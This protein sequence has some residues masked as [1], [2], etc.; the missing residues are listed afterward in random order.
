MVVQTKAE[1]FRGRGGYQSGPNGNPYW[2]KAF[3]NLV[4]AFWDFYYKINLHLQ[5]VSCISVKNQSLPHSAECWPPHLTNVTTN[6]VQSQR[7]L[8]DSKVCSSSWF[9]IFLYY[10]DFLSW[11]IEFLSNNANCISY[12]CLQALI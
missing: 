1:K 5:H 12:S 6:N 3:Q 11:Q 9:F 10:F 4:P 7:Q 2:G 8:L